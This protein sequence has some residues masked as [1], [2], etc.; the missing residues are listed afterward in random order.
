MN[1]NAYSEDQMI[2]AGTADFFAEHLGWRSEYAFGREDFGP[3]S[4]FG[5]SHRGEVVLPWR[6]RQALRKLNPKAPP[7]AI[8]AAISQLVDAEERRFVREG[9]D[10]DE[11][12]AIYDLLPRLEQRKVL[13]DCWRERAASRAQVETAILDHLYKELP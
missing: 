2:Q 11:Q 3:N 9:F 12:L 8:E 13:A 7:A 5:R 6:L 1:A 4:L 10:N